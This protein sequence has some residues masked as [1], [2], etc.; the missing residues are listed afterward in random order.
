MAATY[1]TVS[2]WVPEV[3]AAHDLFLNF[4]QRKKK[5]QTISSSSYRL[6]NTLLVPKLHVA[7][8]ERESNVKRTWRVEYSFP[9]P[10][11]FFP[12]D[13]HRTR[14][15]KDVQ[16]AVNKTVQLPHYQLLLST[17]SSRRAISATF[18]N[19]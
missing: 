9:R 12:R 13:V 6:I 14:G 18:T 16:G 15:A 3:A 10:V 2:W 4:L 5:T 8:R 7:G 17:A 11:R 1:S 19:I